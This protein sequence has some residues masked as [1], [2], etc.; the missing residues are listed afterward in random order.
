MTIIL[1]AVIIGVIPAIIARRKGRSFGLWY[2][3]GVLVFIVALPHAIL[4]SDHNRTRC[5]QCT[6][7]IRS[8][9]TICPYCRSPRQATLRPVYNRMQPR[10]WVQSLLRQGAAPP[11][12]EPLDLRSVPS[13]RSRVD[14][15]P[16]AVKPTELG[17][18][19]SG[20]I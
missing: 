5:S 1:V 11:V 17:S 16:N 3:Y 19:Q 6:E 9:A 7:L 2:L 13:V 20:P 4:M 8:E 14:G 18:S 15:N 12:Y 10:P